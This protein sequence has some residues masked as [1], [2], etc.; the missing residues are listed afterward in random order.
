MLEK[1]KKRYY[2][3]EIHRVWDCGA[4]WTYDE[5]YRDYEYVN[6]DLTYECE[7]VIKRSKEC[8]R[9]DYFEQIK[10]QGCFYDFVYKL[11]GFTN[12]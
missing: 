8:W 7:G 2:I 5:L 6:V 11:E 10:N 9:K 12:E 4:S 1:I 3:K